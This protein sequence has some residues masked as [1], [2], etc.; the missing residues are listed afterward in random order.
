MWERLEIQCDPE[1]E[2][3]AVIAAAARQLHRASS[4]HDRVGMWL[5]AI[6]LNIYFTSLLSDLLTREPTWAAENRW[7]DGISEGEFALTPP[8]RLL[9]RGPVIW[10][11]SE[12]DGPEQWASPLEAE[13]TFSPGFAELAG[14]TIRFGD[15]KAHL[16]EQLVL[17]LPRI[18][19]DLEG[20][21]I[22]WSYE[23]RLDSG[24]T[25]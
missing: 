8:S 16:R 22:E 12:G 23:F 21:S 5:A 10:G 7:L 9:L 14:Y 25:A 18:H 24:A 6:D 4:A 17:S 13:L 20:G 1:P 19:Q 3:Q 2:G 11:L 15:R